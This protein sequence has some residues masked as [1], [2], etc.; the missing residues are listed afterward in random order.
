MQIK[1]INPKCWHKKVRVIAYLREV[2]AVIN[3]PGTGSED[4]LAIAN[5]INKHVAQIFKPSLNINLCRKFRC[6]SNSLPVY[7]LKGNLLGKC[8]YPNMGN[9]Q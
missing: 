4:A 6:F 7:S 1:D 3:M 2:K 8:S 9:S 5:I